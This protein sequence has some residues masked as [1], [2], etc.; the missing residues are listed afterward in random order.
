MTRNTA[1]TSQKSYRDLLNSLKEGTQIKRV[2][3]FIRVSPPVCNRDISKGTGLEIGA[4]TARVNKLASM[5]LI[6]CNYERLHEATKRSVQYWGISEVMDNAYRYLERAEAADR[7]TTYKLIP[8]NKAVINP[9][10]VSMF[11]GLN[12]A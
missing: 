5:G 2:Y 12:G 7:R 1:L 3:D 8:T 9:A 11:G 6:K 10:Q 4:V